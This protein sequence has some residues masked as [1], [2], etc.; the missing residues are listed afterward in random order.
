MK[1]PTSHIL[2]IVLIVVTS[3]CVSEV[4]RAYQVEQNRHFMDADVKMQMRQRAEARFPAVNAAMRAAYE[5]GQKIITPKLVKTVHP[6]FPKTKL[7]SRSQ[8]GVWIAFTLD[9]SGSVVELTPL[10]DE[11]A[12]QDP[13]FVEAAV[14][15]V[16]QW[17]FS[18]A[19]A[20]GKPMPYL[21]VVPVLFQ[22][23][24]LPNK[25]LQ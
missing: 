9:E 18:P 4:E 5:S 2:A 1:A 6:E 11:Q 7:K 12:H 3:G 17:K 24:W 20:D 23:G 25:S 13:E 16:Q 8:G 22:M 21:L 10:T 19:S 14:R 15:A